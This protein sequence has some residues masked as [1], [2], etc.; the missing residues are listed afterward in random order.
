MDLGSLARLA[1]GLIAQGAAGYLGERGAKT[2]WEAIAKQ[3]GRGSQ[4]T[5]E[6]QAAVETG[7]VPLE[8]VEQ[9]I[10]TVMGTH[11]AMEPK[12]EQ[13]VTAVEKGLP[14]LEVEMEVPSGTI[15]LGSR[16]YVERQ[17]WEGRAMQ[18]LGRVAGLVRIKAPR[19]MGKTSMLVRLRDGARQQ[20]YRTVL[21]SFQGWEPQVFGSVERVCFRICDRLA[22]G[23]GLDRQAFKRYWQDNYDPD[24]GSALDCATEYMEEVVLPQGDGPLVLGLD[25]VEAIFP[26]G[27]VVTPGDGDVAGLE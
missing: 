10:L 27:K 18:A 15:Q 24:Y 16:F 13:L 17:P 23:L 14:L 12:L 26:Y 3:L 22:K 25:E 7:Q 11:A 20:N 6:L 2:I 8:E 1:A 9:A 4:D 21:L 19:Q 5:S